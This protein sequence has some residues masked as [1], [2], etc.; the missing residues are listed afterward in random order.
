[1]L[2]AHTAIFT[3]VKGTD[4][5]IGGTGHLKVQGTYD[6]LITLPTSQVQAN[7]LYLGAIQGSYSYSYRAS[8]KYPG[9][10]SRLLG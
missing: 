7:Q 1:M 9:P 8:Y 2:K 5:G 3:E 10:P 4:A 6:S